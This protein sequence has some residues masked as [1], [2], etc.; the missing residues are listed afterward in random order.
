MKYLAALILAAGSIP[1]ADFATG[2]AARAVIGQ[3]TFTVQATDPSQIVSEAKGVI[4]TLLGGAGGLAYANGKLFVADC[5]RIG[6]VPNNYRVLIFNDSSFLPAPT[7]EV[8]QGVRCPLCT[9]QPDLVLGQADFTIPDPTTGW[10]L[11]QTAMRLPTALATDGTH[12]GVADTDNNRVLIWNSIPTTNNAPADV[13]LGQP[14]FKTGTPNTGT[15]DVR[16][17]NAKTLRGPQ[18]VWFQNGKLFV[19]DDMNHRVLIWNSIPTSNY[20]AA[21]LVLGQPNFSTAIEPDLTKTTLDAAS[22]TLL[23]PVAVTS[24]GVHLFVTDLGHNRVLIWNSIP[25]QNQQPADVEIGQPDM[26][27]A[28]ANYTGSGGMCASNGTDSDGNATYPDLCAPTLNYPRFALSDG[29]RLFIA[30]GGN[31]RVLIFN[32]IPTQN[33]ASADLLLGQYDFLV[34][35][36]S[37]TTDAADTARRAGS[38]SLR[39]PT[40]LAWDGVNL[41][42]SEPYSRRI[43]VFT[44]GDQPLPLTAVRNAASLEIYAVGS[45]VLSGTI[46]AKD[47][48]TITIQSKAYKY[49]VKNDDTFAMVV[50]GLVAA[51]NADSGDPNVLAT[52]NYALATV[53]LTSRAGGEAGDAITLAASVSTSATIVANASGANL[54]GG[55][56]AAKIASGTLVAVFGENVS[57]TTAYAPAGSD[58][59][60]TKLG[61]V[62]VYIDG[63]RCPLLAVS[64][65]QINAQVPTE[66]LDSTSVSAYIRTERADGTV[67]TTTAAGVPIVPANPG[68]F[69][70]GGA[71]PRPG[72]VLHGTSQATGTVIIEGTAKASDVATVTINDRTYS[73]TEVDGDTLY[74]IRDHLLDQINASDPEVYALASSQWSYIRLRARIEGPDGNGI[75]ISATGNTD[76]NLTMSTSNTA[77]CCANVAGAPVNDDNPAV[78]GELLTVFATG[79]GM[80]QPDAAK[81]AVTTGFTYK[82]PALNQPN[83]FVSSLAGGSSAGVYFAAMK[84]GEVGIFQVDLE[85]N[86]NLPTNPVTQC[87]IAQ[88]IYVS[89]II[90]FPVVNPNPPSQ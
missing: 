90:T 74:T 45:V 62:E 79:L 67:T 35:H 10:G 17:P 8:P 34:V 29:T 64:P 22:N 69:A 20:Q 75:S 2:Q 12:L 30:D 70:Q 24:D 3:P 57:D 63:I 25:T 83:V 89:N 60:P 76:G 27:T 53:A 87:T 51:I 77:L 33:G 36:T 39:T 72:V 46:T 61:G 1:A 73:Y 44:V 18:G 23:N 88:D 80:I 41:F 49:T 68:I 13:V 85:L 52:P 9:S 47:V 26:S 81:N 42:V 78:P 71:D 5:N 86:A 37:D 55:G 19:A 50:D 59:L 84:V 48:V 40:S 31:D 7:A 58:P 21:D 14:D 54:A 66:V 82:G 32:H 43:M 16:V 15:G 11:S 65:T 38:D 6:A 4:T 56:D 28:I